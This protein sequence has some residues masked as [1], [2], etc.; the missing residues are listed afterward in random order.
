MVC[1]ASYGYD[2]FLV[3]TGISEYYVVAYWGRNRPVP[4]GRTADV[5]AGVLAV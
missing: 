4:V 5:A 1:V 2:W 3:V